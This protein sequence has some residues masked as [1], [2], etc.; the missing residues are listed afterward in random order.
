[1]PNDLSTS[2]TFFMISG[3]VNILAFLGW[4]TNTVITGIFTCGFGCL[5]GVI[6]IVNAI[7]AVM[8]FMAYNKLNSL[9][10]P[11]TYTTCN[12]AA[13]MQIVTMVSG[14]IVSMIFGILNLQYLGKEENK[15]YLKEKGIN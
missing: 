10:Q 6:P 1:M 7:G 11:G 14:N 2:K 9:N 5:L 8:D 4:G 12:N 3:I 15:N 13:I